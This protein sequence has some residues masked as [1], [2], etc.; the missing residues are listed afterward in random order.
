[1]GTRRKTRPTSASTKTPATA[2]RTSTRNSTPSRPSPTTLG[3]ALLHVLENVDLINSVGELFE[4]LAV[5]LLEDWVY[6]QSEFDKEKDKTNFRQYED[7][8]DRVKNFYK[9]QQASADWRR[10]SIWERLVSGSDSSIRVL[11]FSMA[12]QT[13]PISASTKTPATASR[14]ST[15]NSTPSRLLPTT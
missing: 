12:S 3:L 14:T 10:C 9:E 5:P 15:R 2:S 6:E 1:V 11:S 4:R 8:S 13:G 7:A